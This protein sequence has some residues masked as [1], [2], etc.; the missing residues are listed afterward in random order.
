LTIAWG[1]LAA[2]PSF[3]HFITA[4]DGKLFDG[5][6]EFRFIS[7]NIPNLLIVEDNMAWQAPNDWLLPDE[8]EL[9]DAFATVSQLGGTVVRSYSIPLQ[10]ADENPTIP[11]Y[12]RGPGQYNEEAFCTFD[13]VLELANKKHIRLIIPLVNN[14]PW[15][16][17]RGEIAGWRGKSADE[18]WSDPQL[19]SD[20]EE[21]IRHILNRTNTLTGVRYA[22]DK[23]ILCWETGNELR[24]A[25]PGWT[26]TIAGF[27]KSLDHHHLVMDGYDA[28]IRPEVLNMP[29]VDIVTTHHYPSPDNS[30][31]LGDQIRA[32]A[33][34]VAGRKVYIIGEFGFVNTGEMQDAMQAI[35]ESRDSGGLLWSLRFRNRM[36]GFYW[37]SE[38]GGLDLYKA[39]HWPPSPMGASYDE[40]GLMNAVRRDAFAIRGLPLPLPPIPAPPKLLP[41]DDPAAIS[42]QGSVGASGY[43]VERTL[44]RGG[45]WQIIATN[46]DEAFTQYRPQFADENVPAGDWFYRVRA[47]N[48]SGISHPSRVVGPVAANVATLVDELADFSRTQSHSDGWKLLNRDSRVVKEDAHRAAGGAGE[49]LI[50]QLPS[51]IDSFRIFAFFPKAASAPTF[52]LSSDGTAF[53]SVAVGA[54][55]AFHG[56]G[57]YGYWL[58][59]EYHA[60]HLGGGMFLKLE[61]HGETQIARVEISHR[62]LRP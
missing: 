25:T 26:E 39:F 28:G 30:T 31:T 10:R 19:I 41:I 24:G 45:P 1:G 47:R 60:E 12:V 33:K 15:Q 40:A 32:D 17:G 42:W 21:M 37:H 18:F 4:R 38:P 48:A 52:S 49:S 14:W 46:V 5:D 59:V 22:D 35:M 16:G 54:E 3:Q 20:F 2:E 9:Q 53:H 23:T 61:L 13:R 6:K 50:Y 7:W 29:E 55:D 27:I 58:P 62:A 36:G 44:Q 11:K 43:Q 56:A 8:F 34:A 51:P 57:D